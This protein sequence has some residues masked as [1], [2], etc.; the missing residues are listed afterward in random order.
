LNPTSNPMS[1][2]KKMI[3]DLKNIRFRYKNSKE[4]TLNFPA[5]Q[6]VE[7]EKVFLLGPSGSGKTT[8]LELISGILSPTAGEVYVAGESLHKLSESARDRFRGE[9]LGFIFQSFN[10]IPYLNVEENILLPSNLYKKNQKNISVGEWLDKLGMAGLEKRPVTELS[11]GQQQRVA[12]A[13][14]LIQRPKL[15]MA[16]EPTSALDFD[17][18]E[19]FI[20]LLFDQ[21]KQDN[22]TLLFVSHDRS[23]MGL[24]DRVIDLTEL[25]QVQAQKSDGGLS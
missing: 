23:L 3:A 20:R 10:L 19:N 17:Q 4:D 7:G 9:H 8:L 2:N 21:C 5:L 15:I 22:T 14:S 16:D 11:K 18:R 24:F 25:N 12:V 6:L 13:R 1:T